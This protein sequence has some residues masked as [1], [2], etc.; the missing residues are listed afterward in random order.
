[1]AG[2]SVL[3]RAWGARARHR[4]RVG[5]R[6]LRALA[7]PHLRERDVQPGRR[8]SVPCGKAHGGARALILATPEPVARGCR[9]HDGCSSPHRSSFCPGTQGTPASDHGASSG[10]LGPPPV[11]AGCPQICGSVPQTSISGRAA[12][13]A[14]PRPPL[15]PVSCCCRPGRPLPRGPSR[16]PSRS[17]ARGVKGPAVP[18]SRLRAETPVLHGDRPGGRDSGTGPLP[19]SKVVPPPPGAVSATRDLKHAGSRRAAVPPRERTRRRARH[20]G[21]PAPWQG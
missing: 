20:A 4:A 2:E 12:P 9:R 1:M 7:G 6:G 11:P 16:G 17:P 5:G 18:S 14:Q 15:L 13:P 21:P 3:G 8:R 10:P 19:G